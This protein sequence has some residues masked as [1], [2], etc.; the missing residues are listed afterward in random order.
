[1]VYSIKFKTIDSDE[2]PDFSPSSSDYVPLESETSSTESDDKPDSGQAKLVAVSSSLIPPP[3]K[4][5]E[6]SDQPSEV[7]GTKR[8]RSEKTWKKKSRKWLGNSGQCLPLGQSG[9]QTSTRSGSEKAVSYSY[10]LRDGDKGE[11]V[12]K[13]YFLDTLRFNHG[14][15][16]RCI[17]KPK[18]HAV[19]DSHG[20][21]TPNNKLDYSDI[22]AHIKSFPD[23]Q[24]HHSRQKNRERKYLHPDLNTRKRFLLLSRTTS[25]VE[26]SLLITTLMFS[27]NRLCGWSDSGIHL[28]LTAAES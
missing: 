17:S 10:I 19:L 2:A 18:V 13:Q 8:E 24:S 5:T 6:S 9:A 28:I 26:S 3:R 25:F 7:R 1:M 20:K 22:V 16:Y 4:S 23:Y 12:C 11:T 21:R 14:R 15:G 27:N